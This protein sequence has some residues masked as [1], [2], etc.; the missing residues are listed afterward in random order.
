MILENLLRRLSAVSLLM[1]HARAAGLSTSQKSIYN[2]SIIYLLC[3]VAE[4]FTFEVVKAHSAKNLHI[5]GTKKE[6]V[7]KYSVPKGVLDATRDSF[8]CEKVTTK[9]SLFDK[10]VTFGEM[11]MYLKNKKV[12][13]E[14]EYLLIDW[15]REERNKIH[16]Q[17]LTEPDTG[18]TFKK[19]KKISKGIKLLTS[20]LRLIWGV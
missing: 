18:F 9:T 7:Q 20:K 6:F 3:T 14:P 13:A 8:L 19:I 12:L 15:I 2:R 11:L 1:D 4:G 17:G 5:I 10:G 16:V